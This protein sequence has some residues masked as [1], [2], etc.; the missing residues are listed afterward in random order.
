[1]Y[2]LETDHD[3]LWNTCYKVTTIYRNIVWR[4]FKVFHSSANLNFDL[5]GGSFTN[6]EAVIAAQSFHNIGGKFITGDTDTL[7]TNNTG[8]SNNRDTRCTT[9]NINDHIPNRFFHINTNSQRSGHGLMNK[10]NFSCASL[11]CTITNSS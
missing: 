2:F 11:F 7:V 9:T 1:S 10:I 8:K 6:Q 3:L 5:L 4:R